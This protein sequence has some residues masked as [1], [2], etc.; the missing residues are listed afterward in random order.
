MDPNPR[1][2]HTRG[3][4]PV[5]RCERRARREDHTNMTNRWN[6][7]AFTF[8]NIFITH[9]MKGDIPKSIMGHLK[10]IYAYC[11]KFS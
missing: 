4:M 2:V 3:V 10:K 7:R 5:G 8:T 9:Y 1:D 6:C 11:Y